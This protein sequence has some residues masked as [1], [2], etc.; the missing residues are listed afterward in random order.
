MTLKSK[1][2][3]SNFVVLNVG[4]LGWAHPSMDPFLVKTIWICGKNVAA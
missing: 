1:V 2:K 4:Y 3:I